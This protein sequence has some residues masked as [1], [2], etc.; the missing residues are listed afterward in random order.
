MFNDWL[1][2]L[3]QK[4]LPDS[5]KYD[6]PYRPFLPDTGAIKLTHG[7]LHRA[8]IIISTTRPPRVLAVVDWGQSGWY[9]DYWEYCKALYTSRI[10]EEWRDQW[11]PK[12]LSP[13]TEEHEVFAEYVLSIGAV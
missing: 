6:D 10:G 9:P 5:L 11:I 1:S 12:F 4:R 7:D 8:N 3:P 13:R 2:W